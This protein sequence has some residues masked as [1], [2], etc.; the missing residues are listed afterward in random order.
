MNAPLAP[1]AFDPPVVR[2]QGV[3]LRYGRRTALESISTC[4]KA[5]WSV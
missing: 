1:E 5:A 3:S 4:P 2:L